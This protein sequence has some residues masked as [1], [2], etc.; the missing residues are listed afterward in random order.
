MK[1][2]IIFGSSGGLGSYLSKKLKGYYLIYPIGKI[3]KKYK[4]NLLIK[5][6]VDKLVRRINPDII[7]NCVASTSVDRCINDYNYAFKGNVTTAQNI[8]HAIK[9]LTKKI[10]LIH[11]STDQVYNSKMFCKNK[12]SQINLSNNYSKTKFLAEQK[13]KKISN[14]TIIRTNFFGKFFSTKLSFS[15]FI[16]KNLKNNKKI[17]MPTNIFYSPIHVNY[18]NNYIVDIIKKNLKG[19]YNIGSQDFISKYDFA[20]KIAELKNLNQNL[21]TKYESKYAKD[22]RPFNTSLNSKKFERV[23]KKKMPYLQKMLKYL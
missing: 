12:E 9:K 5:N 18:L 14:Y 20:Y 17:L 21:I 2:V 19:I 23:I 22:K 3:K 1:K 10:H 16:I 8:V 15:D 7:I 11:I 13:I 4:V 6:D